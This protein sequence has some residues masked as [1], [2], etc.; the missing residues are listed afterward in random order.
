MDL[1]IVQDNSKPN[2]VR[3]IGSFFPL[4]IPGTPEI[5]ACTI[6]TMKMLDRLN[7]ITVMYKE[8]Q[9]FLKCKPIVS[10]YLLLISCKFDMEWLLYQ[11]FHN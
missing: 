3:V 5:A 9:S 10:L 11:F 7:V 6:Y 8:R 2:T 4:H 1:V